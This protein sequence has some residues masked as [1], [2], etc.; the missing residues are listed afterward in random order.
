MTFWQLTNSDFSTNQTFH[1]FHDLRT[2]FDLHRIMSGFH[3]AFATG[4]ACQQ[5]TLT[6][7]DTW[8]RPPILGLACAPI[9]ET[10]FPR[11]CHVFT[12]LSPQIPFS[13]FS[14]LL[15]ISV[16]KF[17]SLCVTLSVRSNELATM[18]FTSYIARFGQV[19][20]QKYSES[21]FLVEFDLKLKKLRWGMKQEAPKCLISCAWV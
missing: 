6:L 4:V 12:R 3:G 11:T 14:I 10:R 2:N 20:L 21:V 18:L 17:K 13:T 19:Q 9:V 16:R 7:P 1:Q 5:G 15:S 8:F